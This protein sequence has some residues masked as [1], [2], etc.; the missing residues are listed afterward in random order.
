MRL[1]RWSLPLVA[2][3]ALMARMALM[4]LLLPGGAWAQTPSQSNQI[5]ARSFL[6]R[7]RVL[8]PAGA[9]IAGARVTAIHD[10]VSGPSTVTDRNGAFTLTLAIGRYTIAVVADGFARSLRP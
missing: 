2:L 8:D 7:G 6:L 5:P 9:S 3:M 10:G 1:C 4:A